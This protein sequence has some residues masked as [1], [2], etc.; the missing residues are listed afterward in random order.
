MRK[1]APLTV[2]R[3]LTLR[4][5]PG[6]GDADLSE[7]ATIAE[8]V[9]ERTFAPRATVA[10]P[11]GRFPAIHLVVEG[12]LEAAASRHAWGPRRLFGALETIAGRAV[13]ERVVAAS[14]TRTLELATADLTELLEDNYS[15]LSSARRTLACRLLALG[16]APAA[17]RPALV[18]DRRR[19][20]G[21]VERLVILR[22]QPRFA[23]ASIQ[24]LS[25]LAQ[26]AEELQIP[27][28]SP[29]HRAGEDAGGMLVILDG[30]ARALR[31]AGP[32][33]LVPGAELGALE[34]LAERPYAADVD[35]VTAVRALRLPGAALLD[36]MED[37]TDFAITLIGRLAGELLDRAHLP[38]EV[39]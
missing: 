3:M 2:Q 34:S 22:A 30:V 31:A 19:P 20:L 24:A 11:G 13:P 8:N 5:L 32:D 4:Q 14:A 27:A 29:I 6:F 28:R 1:Y 16:A 36:V 18:D 9:V 7:L 26:A 33:T 10:E 12:R 25:A 21:M 39:N 38:L 37:H 35:A 23:G 15:V 17:H